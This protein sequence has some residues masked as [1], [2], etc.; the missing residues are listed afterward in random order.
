MLQNGIAL[1]DVLKEN[2]AVTTV[3]TGEGGTS[4]GDFHEALNIASVWNLPVIFCVENNGYGLST[5]TREQYNCENLVDR[6]K[7]YGIEGRLL[8][9]NNILEVYTK[10]SELARAIRKRPRPVLLEFRTFRMRGHEEASG[11]KYVPRELILEWEA[12][13]PIKN[14]QD[15]LVEEGVV[16]EDWIYQEKQKITSEIEENLQIASDEPA[17]VLDE[18]KELHEVYQNADI[19]RS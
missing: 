5:P 13:D 6:A 19:S 1:A 17:I 8:D 18:S 11:T 14:F 2:Q 15:F 10:V 16:D 9:G 7:G 12:K 3:F 4:E